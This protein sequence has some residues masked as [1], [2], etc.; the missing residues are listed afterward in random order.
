MTASPTTETELSLLDTP[1]VT[2]TIKQS[3]Y[4]EELTPSAAGAIDG[5]AVALL[6]DRKTRP[7]A[8]PLELPDRLAQHERPTPS[9]D[10]YDQLLDR[11]AVGQ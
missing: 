3:A 8:D 11:E 4:T 6:I 5:R 10:E 7:P 1:E 9:L 2:V